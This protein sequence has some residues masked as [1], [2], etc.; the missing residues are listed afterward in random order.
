MSV[1]LGGQT[2][3]A[4]VLVVDDEALVRLVTCEHLTEG[5][6]TCIEAGTGEE[7]LRILENRPD[8][9]LVVTDVHMP[10]VVDGF[11][12]ANIIARRWPDVAVIVLSGGAVSVAESTLPAG[13]VYLAKP[14][15][16][17]ELLSAVHRARQAAIAACNDAETAS[18]GPSVVSSPPDIP[19][20]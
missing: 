6:H 5:G 12:L 18:D 2:T 11:A 19:D 8:V 1:S 7:G 14:C 4:A 3:G 15:L 17:A 16:A 20:A 9:W 10:G 13:A